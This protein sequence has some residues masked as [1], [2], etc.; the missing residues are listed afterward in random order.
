VSL[1]AAIE[2]EIQIRQEDL[3]HDALQARPIVRVSGHIGVEA[4]EAAL[5]DLRESRMGSIFRR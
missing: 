1:V 2:E 3:A 4:V 5:E